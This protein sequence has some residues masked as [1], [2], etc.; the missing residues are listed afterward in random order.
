MK[1]LSFIR[2]HSSWYFSD[3]ICTSKSY[4]RV[5]AG[6]WDVDSSLLLILKQL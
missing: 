5:G 1:K 4:N 2:H 3:C 6:F